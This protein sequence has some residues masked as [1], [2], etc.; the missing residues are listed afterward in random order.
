MWCQASNE[1]AWQPHRSHLIQQGASGQLHPS[2]C[3]TC[4]VRRYFLGSSFLAT[5]PQDSSISG[6]SLYPSLTMSTQAPLFPSIHPTTLM[7]HPLCLAMEKTW[8]TIATLFSV[9]VDLAN[10]TFG[11]YYWHLWTKPM[12]FGTQGT[13]LI[14]TCTEPARQVRCWSV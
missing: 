12:P 14:P 2:Q 1:S 3:G 10:D 8:W 6:G 13:Y 11:F 4:K 7:E 5:S 9:F